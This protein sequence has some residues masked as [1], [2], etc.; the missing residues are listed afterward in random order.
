[1]LRFVVDNSYVLACINPS[2]LVKND[3]LSWKDA[4][5][6]DLSV[7]ATNLKKVHRI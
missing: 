1:M 7:K 4:G 2:I 5:R 6:E 3:F